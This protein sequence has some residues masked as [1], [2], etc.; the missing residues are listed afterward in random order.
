[1]GLLFLHR[2]LKVLGFVTLVTCLQL[3]GTLFADE[4]P[5]PA[6]QEGQVLDAKTGRPVVFDDLLAHLADQDVIYLGEE[7]RNHAHIQAA[8]QVLQGLLASHVK[9]ILALEMFSWDGQA[10]LNRYLADP[11]MARQDFLRDSR[12]EQNWGGEMADYEPLMAFARDHHLAVVAMNPP[13]PLVRRVASQGLAQS[14]HDPEMARWGM[15]EPFPED[16]AYHDM[17]VKP[18]RECHGGLSDQDYQ[19]MYDASLFRDEGMAKTIVDHLR[20]PASQS[21]R[22]SA[23]AG[24]EP[25]RGLVV[26][27]T[28]GGHIQYQLPVPLRVLRRAGRPVK[29]L[30]IYLTSFDPSRTDEIRE[31][32]GHG[33][34]DYIW[35]TPQSA[36]GPPRRCGRR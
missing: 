8:L 27:Y 28:G 22:Q 30:S 10:G 3:T 9:P 31:Y 16:P 23:N 25:T 18:L 14:L 1:M 29:Q 12:W 36:Q 2:K 19:R 6:L 34:A 13:R 15:T 11:S 33:I 24:S 7:H 17:I 32:L 4:A 35:L 26:S 21:D 20:P 5:S